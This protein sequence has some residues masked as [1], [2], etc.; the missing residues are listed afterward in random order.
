MARNGP[1]TRALDR[2]VHLPRRGRAT[3]Q[4]AE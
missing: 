3:L 2:L 4:P 1:I